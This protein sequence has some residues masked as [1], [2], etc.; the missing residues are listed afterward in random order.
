MKILIDLILFDLW[1]F[2]QYITVLF[3]IS[4]YLWSME[5]NNLF[6]RPSWTWSYGSWIYNQLC[7]QCLSPLTL[8]CV[9][10]QNVFGWKSTWRFWLIWFYLTYGVFNSILQ[11]YRGDQ[12][13]WQEKTIDLSQ[14]TD[15]L[16]PILY[17][18]LR[19]NS[20]KAYIIYVISGYSLC[21]ELFDWY[22]RISWYYSFI[23]AINFIGRR[24]PST[25]HK[26]LTNFITYCIEYTSP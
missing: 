15:K 19:W 21:V 18:F 6:W 26:S 7:N 20:S 24:K 1:G 10:V 13:Y 22:F 23:V 25:C 8:W 14:V 3:S 11:F 9:V 17:L 5:C 4:G 12:F 2:Q 16:Y